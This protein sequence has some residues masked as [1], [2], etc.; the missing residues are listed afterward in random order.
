MV[1]RVSKN[2]KGSLCIPSVS[3]KGLIKNQTFYI[4]DVTI[5]KPDVQNALS[6]QWIIPTDGDTPII[7]NIVHITN[8][9]NGSVTIP[10]I[11]VIRAGETRAVLESEA[12]TRPVEELE[13]GKIIRV[14]K[15]IKSV[16]EKRKPGRPRKE[17]KQ[18]KEKIKTT[19]KDPSEWNPLTWNPLTEDGQVATKPLPQLLKLAENT[20]PILPTIKIT[21]PLNRTR[22]RPNE[23]DNGP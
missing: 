11:G 1:V 12:A 9:S 16:I 5:A 10:I 4:D 18:V 6:K 7:K 22:F 19:Q 8:I 13:K 3:Q 17:P 15:R 2:F 14:G 20:E 21:N 23:S